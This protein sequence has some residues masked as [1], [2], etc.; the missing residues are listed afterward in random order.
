MPDA[1]SSDASATDVPATDAGPPAGP[2]VVAPASDSDAPEGSAA[3][4]SAG[5]KVLHLADERSVRDLEEFAS[6]ARRVADTGMRLTVAAPATAGRPPL[7]AQWVSVLQPAGLGDAVPVVLGLRTVPL[8]SAS[9]VEGLDVVV[10]LAAVGERTARMR[11]AAGEQARA[12]TLPPTREQVAWTAL[13]PPRSGWQVRA[14]VGEDELLEVARL[15]AEA[16]R[17]ALPQDPGEALVRRVRAQVWSPALGGEVSFPA[18][19]AFGA[20]ALGFLRPG[21]RARVAVNGPWRRLDTPGGFVLGR[22]AVGV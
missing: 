2:A 21:G 22:A 17:D 7:L 14:E 18:G 20:H 1:T 8:A 3:P 19:M 15:G 9:G 5:G 6:R 10:P 4:E 13:T 12:F 16:V 11:S